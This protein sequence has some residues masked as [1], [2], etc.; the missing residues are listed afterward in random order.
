MIFSNLV[1]SNKA[2]FLAKVKTKEYNIGYLWCKNIF[3]HSLGL[4][5]GGV[6]LKFSPDGSIK[7]KP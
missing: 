4:P 7:Y 2:E 6:I 3:Y 5:F 1:L